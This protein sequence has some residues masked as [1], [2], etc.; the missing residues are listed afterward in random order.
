MRGGLKREFRVIVTHNC[1]YAN[2]TMIECRP[3]FFCDAVKLL[4]HSS[5]DLATCH[6]QSIMHFSCLSTI[7]HCCL[8]TNIFIHIL[9]YNLNCKK[10]CLRYISTILLAHTLPIFKDLKLFRIADIFK[11][12]LMSF[13]YEASNK[14]APDCFHDFSSLN[15]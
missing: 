14:I 7:W 9:N 4:L 15:S 5:R 2:D 11:V 1:M 3:M 6:H 8:G 12:R 10:S 13:V